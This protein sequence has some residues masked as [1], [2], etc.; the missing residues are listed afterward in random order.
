M[1]TNASVVGTEADDTINIKNDTVGRTVVGLGGDDTI[2]ATD[3]NDLVLAGWGND[4]VRGNAGNDVIRGNDSVPTVAPSTGSAATGTPTGTG[5][6]AFD[7]ENAGF[8]SAVGMY[9]ISADG[10]ISDVTLLFE[11][12]DNA[13]LSAGD[14]ADLNL[15]AGDAIGFFLLPNAWAIDEAN[16]GADLLD[17]SLTYELRHPNSLQPGTVG[18]GKPLELWSIDPITTAPR[19]VEGQYDTFVFHTATDANPDGAVHARVTENTDGTLE[20]SFEDLVNGGNE[21][22]AAFGDAVFTIDLQG[23][24]ARVLGSP[25]ESYTVGPDGSITVGGTEYEAVPD[26]ATTVDVDGTPGT[27]SDVEV[28]TVD[29]V[30]HIVVGGEVTVEGTAG[31]KEGALFED[32]PGVVARDAGIDVCVVGACAFIGRSALSA[33]SAAMLGCGVIG[34]DPFRIA[35]RLADRLVGQIALG[36]DAAD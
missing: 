19:L 20:V 13:V 18:S 7:S 3:F 16:G 27:V 5:T 21:G 34:E 25:D 12:V 17:P 24:D 26:G 29:G 33:G 6:I 32:V 9:K 35:D 4:V 8:K 15:A 36:P 10:T 1:S 2:S 14:T 11:N 31:V 28:V 22:T 23:N 30:R